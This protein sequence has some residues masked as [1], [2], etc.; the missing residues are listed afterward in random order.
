M[1]TT[2]QLCVLLLAIAARDHLCPLAT[3]GTVYEQLPPADFNGELFISSTINGIGGM[4]GFRVADDFQLT[5]DAT[6]DHVQWWGDPRPRTNDF[7]FAFYADNAGLPGPLLLSTGGHRLISRPTPGSTGHYMY[8]IHLNTPFAAAS[9][10]KYWFSVFDQGAESRWEWLAA[11]ADYGTTNA[12]T[13]VPPGDAWSIKNQSAL[14]YRLIASVAEPSPLVFVGT[15]FSIG[16]L[17][18][19]RRASRSQ[20]SRSRRR[21]QL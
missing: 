12:F 11:S 8:A 17:L 20:K 15:A 3:A 1:T 7:S 6:I 2:S 21:A 16:G 5:S 14:S 4:P 10:T 18:Y 9:G 19:C 13:E